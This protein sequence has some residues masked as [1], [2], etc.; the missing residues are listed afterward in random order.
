MKKSL[1]EL[2]LKKEVI[3][4]LAL[5]KVEGGG[6]PPG[7]GGNNGGNNTVFCPTVGALNTCPP[8]GMQ[9]F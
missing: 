8:P 4:K 6:C 7:G 9:C 2:Q 5:N 1:K 3:S